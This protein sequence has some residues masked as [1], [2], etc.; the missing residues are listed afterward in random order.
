MWQVIVQKNG[1]CET[2]RPGRER[3]HRLVEVDEVYC[4]GEEE[5][6]HGREIYEKTLIVIASEADGEGIGR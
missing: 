4:G 1:V 3:L 5:D 6:V 2:V